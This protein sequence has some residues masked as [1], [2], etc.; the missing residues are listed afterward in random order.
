M[1]D[2]QHKT[3]MTNI[4]Q[5]TFE[6]FVQ[7]YAKEWTQMGKAAATATAEEEEVEFMSR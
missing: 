1:V 5:I 7:L 2:T 6:Q 3:R 4:I